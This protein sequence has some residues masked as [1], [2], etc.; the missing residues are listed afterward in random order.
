MDTTVVLDEPHFKV[1]SEK[2]RILGMTPEK[3]LQALID[4]DARSFDEILQPVRHGFGTMSDEQIDD[5]FE[6]A[7][8]AAR[9]RE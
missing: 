3:Y 4:A 6:R 2:A 7:Q 8:R 9:Q 5:L 1:V